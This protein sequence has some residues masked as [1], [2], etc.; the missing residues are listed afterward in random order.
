[1]HAATSDHAQHDRAAAA[2]PQAT[3]AIAMATIMTMPTPARSRSRLRHDGRSRHQQASLRSSRRRPIISARPAAAPNSPPIPQSISTKRSRRRPVARGHDLHLPDASARSA[4]SVPAAARS[5]AWRWS[6][7]VVEPRRA[8]QSRTRR[9]DAA[10]LDRACAARRC[11]WCLEMG[12]HLVGGHGWIDPTLSNWIQLV[13]RHAGGALGRLAV[14]RARL[15]IAGNAQS[16]HVHADRDGHRRGLCSTAWSRTVAPQHFPGGVSRPWRRGRG[17][18]R[19]RRRHHRAGAA[20]PGAGAARPRGD[21]RRD[22]GAAGTRA[23]DRAP[24][25]A[26]TAP[27]TKSRSTALPSATGCAFAPARRCRSTASFSRAARRSINRW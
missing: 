16:Q 2:A 13:V 12:G 17:L 23:E 25:R 26:T 27:S 24:R 6:R 9:H 14:L 10:L 21:V 5:A 7:M 15:A 20:R 1:M 4:R 3:A 8:A 11:R 18:F 19:S 22:Q